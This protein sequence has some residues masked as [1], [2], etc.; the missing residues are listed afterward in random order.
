MLQQTG[1]FDGAIAASKQAIAL[2]PNEVDARLITGRG[3]ST[4]GRCWNRRLSSFAKLFGL[5]RMSPRH[6]TYLGYALGVKG[7][8]QD[9]ISEFETAV[10]LKPDFAEAQYYL[11]AARWF[12]NDVKGAIAALT[13]AVKLM[14]NHANAHYYLGLALQKS[15]NLKAQSGSCHCY[16]T[17]TG[18]G[19]AAPGDGPRL[20]AE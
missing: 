6:I 1:D 15:G 7:L 13:T 18:Y 2:K 12:S 5:S 4:E 20:T 17:R 3:L 16:Q 19:R 9:S 14:P 10:R 8:L 11:G